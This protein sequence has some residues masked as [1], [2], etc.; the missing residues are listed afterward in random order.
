MIGWSNQGLLP[1]RED[2]DEAQRERGDEENGKL[3]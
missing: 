1:H 3:S 2:V